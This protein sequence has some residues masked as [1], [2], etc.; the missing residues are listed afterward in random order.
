MAEDGINTPRDVFPAFGA[1][2][3]LL[4]TTKSGIESYV[5]G[6]P[7]LPQVFQI[8]TP[9][10][11]QARTHTSTST[12][13]MVQ[14]VMQTSTLSSAPPSAPVQHNRLT[15]GK[16][17]AV[18]VVPLIVMAI[19]S[20]IL[21]VWLLSWRRRRRSQRRRTTRRSCSDPP[22]MQY[23]KQQ[24]SSSRHHGSNRSSKRSR[25]VP[26]PSPTYSSFNFGLPRADSLRATKVGRRPLPDG[27]RSQHSLVCP[28]DA[29]APPPYTITTQV[30]AQPA[31]QTT[32][33]QSPIPR[34]DTPIFPDSPL[35]ET[36]Q[37]V[38]IR[39]ISNQSP[40][41]NNQQPR[42]HQSDTLQPPDT[43]GNIR[44]R[45]D[46][47]ESEFSVHNR[48]TLRQPF[49]PMASPTF[50]DVSGLSFDP[51][52]WASVMYGRDS[53]ISP[54]DADDQDANKERTSPRQIV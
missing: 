41:R 12:L 1:P 51:T 14:Q 39:P 52:L 2:K 48:A 45:Q 22:L 34:I 7:L 5:T 30:I 10:T 27:P 28:W 21:I 3:I 36:A 46:S 49:S 35:L 17:A 4:L 47:S 9:Q 15:S 40:S 23:H 18:I 44:T 24:H 6:A 50:S 31:P 20:P 53:I 29:E 13:S 37:M 33:S 43:Y 11:T 25:A 16:L 32:R 19:A 54:I 8:D 38:H 42:R 26:R